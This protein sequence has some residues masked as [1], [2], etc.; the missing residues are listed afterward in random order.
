MRAGITNRHFRRVI[1]LIGGLLLLL[2]FTFDLQVV[3]AQR[4][5]TTP[6]RAS[7]PK[8]TPKPRTALEQMGE[9]PPVPTLKKQPEQEITPGDVVKVDTTEVMFPVTVRDTSGRFINDLT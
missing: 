5:R 1:L 3:D 9:P 2:G 7:Q 8:P 6:Q 4:K